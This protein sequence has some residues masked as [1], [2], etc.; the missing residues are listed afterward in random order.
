MWRLGGAGMCRVLWLVLHC[1]RARDL[2]GHSTNVSLVGSESVWGRRRE[3]AKPN[4]C[5]SEKIIALNF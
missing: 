3:I 2:S 5:G 4:Q 1:K